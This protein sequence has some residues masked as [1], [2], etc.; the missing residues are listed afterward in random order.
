M[1]DTCR[2]R[3][4]SGFTLIE[5]LVVIAIIGILIA[6]LLPAVQKVRESANR[7]V[8]Q[9]NLKQIALAANGYQDVN[10]SLPAGMDQQHVAALVYLLPYLEQV[11]T[12]QKFSFD[13]NPPNP[14]DPGFSYP[15]V[16]AFWWDNG[17]NYPPPAGVG[18]AAPAEIPAYNY[19]PRPPQLYG[20]TLFG[21]E[22]RVRVFECPS[23]PD[24]TTYKTMLKCSAFGEPPGYGYNAY[25]VPGNGG[26]SWFARSPGQ[27]LRGVTH[28]VACGGD[29]SYQAFSSNNVVTN[30]HGLEG[31]FWYKTPR[32]LANI[33]DGT[34]NTMAFME[35]HMGYQDATWM[36]N[37]A[38]Y[39]NGWVGRYWADGYDYTTWGT[40]PNAATQLPGD[41]WQLGNQPNPCVGAGYTLGA[42]YFGLNPQAAGSMH[43]NHLLQIAMGDGSVRTIDPGIDY[44]V[45]QA[46]GGW[47]DGMLANLP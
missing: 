13:Q 30:N 42:P 3:R 40:C 9:D 14:S 6:L 19:I 43:G 33:P 23:A 1:K 18:A 45:W 8:C 2:V 31:M 25:F 4:R 44:A 29:F 41:A 38:L 16:H 28:Y 21:A 37:A 24:P 20:Q 46:I 32:S 5:L 22:T 12:F 39:Q 10:G 15:L 26:A 34:S 17:K 11:A 27:L 47:K 35:W 7:S 36:G